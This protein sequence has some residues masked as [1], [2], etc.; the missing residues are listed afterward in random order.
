MKAVCELKE[1]RL[2]ALE[3]EVLYPFKTT[4]SW[5]LL[6][7]CVL[8]MNVWKEYIVNFYIDDFKG[9]ELKIK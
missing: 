1:F 2:T 9:L 5:S 8:I 7:L 6:Y 4:S 3:T